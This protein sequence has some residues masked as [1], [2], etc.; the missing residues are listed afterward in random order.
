[1]E[2]EGDRDM[3]VGLIL[4]ARNASV[5]TS[6]VIVRVFR[7]KIERANRSCRPLRLSLRDNLVRAHLCRFQLL[8]RQLLRIIIVETSFLQFAVTYEFY[9]RPEG[10]Q[11]EKCIVFVLEQ[12]VETKRYGYGNWWRGIS[13]V[14]FVRSTGRHWLRCLMC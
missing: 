8:E 3:G 11:P 5:L 10:P 13:G 12:Q 4:R 1:M 6:N 2:L 9:D 14:T 7:R